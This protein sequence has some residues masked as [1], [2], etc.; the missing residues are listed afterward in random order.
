MGYMDKFLIP[1]AVLV[2]LLYVF[3]VGSDI[4]VSRRFLRAGHWWWGGWTAAFVVL[5]WTIML[6]AAFLN[7][8]KIGDT[9]S[10]IC[11]FLAFFGLLAIANLARAVWFKSKGD[12]EN[13]EKMKSCAIGNLLGELIFE[14]YP[15]FGLQLYIAAYTNKLDALQH[16]G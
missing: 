14:S 11:V 8:R 9:P 16:A 13:A 7:W 10:L 4:L 6:A 5:H 3:D 1:L 2:A 12:V 15:Q